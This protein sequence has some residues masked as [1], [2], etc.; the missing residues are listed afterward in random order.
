MA[1][2]PSKRIE[3]LA[4]TALAAGATA[5]GYA[6]AG[7]TLGLFIAGF[8]AVTFLTPIFVAR[9]WPMVIAATIGAAGVWLI[10]VISA[11]D[12]ISEWFSIV[13]VLLGYGLF[14]SG[15]GAV[16]RCIGIGTVS[17][18]AIGMLLGIAWLT[19]P[20]WLRVSDAGWTNRLVELHPPLVAN[21]VLHKEQPWTERVVAYHL[22][23]LDQNVP[24][25]LPT[26]GIPC[27]AVS[28]ITGLA[29][30]FAAR[31]RTGRRGAAASPVG[32]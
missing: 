9:G 15:V 18:G 6:S 22:T 27:A 17:A 19:W 26:S 28:G 16:C 5:I 29:L 12:R 7:A 30:W 20:I 10:G 23:D 32:N 13:M 14:I 3:W 21:G 31:A 1:K 4:T 8:F 24:I 11:G 25:Q 2:N